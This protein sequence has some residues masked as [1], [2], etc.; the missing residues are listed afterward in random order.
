[1]PG[2][3]YRQAGDVYKRQE[4]GKCRFNRVFNGIWADKTGSNHLSE[5]DGAGD[6]DRL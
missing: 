1:M 4:Y 5:S 6:A 2:L 3:I